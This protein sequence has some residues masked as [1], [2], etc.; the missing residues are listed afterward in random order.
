MSLSQ[1]LPGSTE[2]GRYMY[3][4]EEKLSQM[5]KVFY[6]NSLESREE[7]KELYLKNR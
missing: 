3:Q 2:R 6:P 1:L 4:K 7:L 5:Q